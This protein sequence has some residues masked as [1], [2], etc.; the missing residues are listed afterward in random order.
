MK[1]TVVGTWVKT[2]SSLYP[3]FVHDNM[4]SA[5]LDPDMPISP[6]DNIEDEK[7]H[8][9]INKMAADAQLTTKELWRIIGKDNVQAFYKMYALFFNK[10]NLY[11]FLNSMNDVH[12]IVR[13][14]IPGSNPPS[15]DIEIISK[16]SIHFIYSSK[17]NMFDY[18][19]GLIEGA[20]EHFNEN[21]QVEEV[22]R[23]DGQLILKLTFPYEVRQ[24]RKY[25][26]NQLLSF[27][28][29]KDF[30]IKVAILSTIFASL[31]LPLFAKTSFA[32][33][34]P[35]VFYP[36]GSILLSYASYFL[37][38]RPLRRLKNELQTIA[39]REFIIYDEIRSGNDFMESFSEVSS[40][41]KTLVAKD[42][43]EFSSMTEEMQNFGVDLS[44]IARNMDI[45]SQ[46]ISDV[47]KQ[48][49]TASHAQAVEAEKVVVVLHE[50][51]EG[52]SNLAAEE[53][54]NKI[55]LESALSDIHI[56]FMGLNETM[57]AMQGIL[58]NFEEL[59]NASGQI[60]T[61]GY[62][63]ESVAKF[64]SDISFQT[65]ILSL[66]ASIE[67]ARA[68]VAGKGFSVVAEEVRM[69]AEQSA[70]A[71]EDIKKNIFGFLKEIEIIADKINGQFYIVNSQNESIQQSVMQAQEANARLEK[72]AEKMVFSI[73]ELGRQNEK[74]N[75]LFDF[76]QAQAALSE[77]NSAATQ[78][79][80][81]NV[82]GFI[83]ELHK[84][85]HG[86]Q[87]FGA[88]TKEFREYI[89]A[90]RI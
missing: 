59:K 8:Q 37:L 27:G 83:Q 28:F 21:V 65:N 50:N 73:E 82:N 6:F 23:K 15:L 9:F 32:V 39:D 38:S 61:R 87:Q 30:G 34:H 44:N 31:L 55:E 14:K 25:R 89:L 7:V 3:Q 49:E 48:L 45:N 43:I 4:R 19:L 10:S 63:I 75:Q 86:I 41:L 54:Q 81:T 24:I 33:E 16:N 29:I 71:A 66:N 60:T 18:L 12:Q 35:A 46:G 13:K 70:G 56:S 64:V 42:F 88:L 47:V 77:Q 57:N 52:L 76:I 90:Y 84:L 68:G 78:I 58:Q 74:I 67:A 51:L 17:R 22:H 26:L 62:E 20:K 85:T 72:I 2:L 11:N 53:N 79:V 1:G 5:G 36:A 40:R 80:G 69:L